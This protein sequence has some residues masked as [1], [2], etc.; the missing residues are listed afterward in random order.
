MHYSDRLQTIKECDLVDVI[1]SIAE[2]KT[3]DLKAVIDDVN[4]LIEQAEKTEKYERV[5]KEIADGYEHCE[6]MSDMGFMDYYDGYEKTEKA[7]EVL[8][9]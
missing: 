3:V 9:T 8:E 6:S 7:K 1:I 5:L 4:W 2:G